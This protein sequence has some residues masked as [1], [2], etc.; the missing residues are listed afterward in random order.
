M[1]YI[2]ISTYHKLYCVRFLVFWSL[3]ERESRDDHHMVF[4]S[5]TQQARNLFMTCNKQVN[6]CAF[7]LHLSGKKKASLKQLEVDL[8][9]HVNTPVEVSVLLCSKGVTIILNEG[10]LVQSILLDE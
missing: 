3:E 9:P 1:H 5:R 2:I 6:S 8:N 10:H 7:I 4:N